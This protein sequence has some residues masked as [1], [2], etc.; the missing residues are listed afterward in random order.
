MKF[1]NS[2]N[3]TGF[4]FGLAGA[5]L[6]FASAYLIIAQSVTMTQNGMGMTLT[7][8]TNPSGI[9]WGVGLAALG[10]VLIVTA[11]VS[12]SSLSRKRMVT[13]GRLMFAYGIVMLL[14]GTSMLSGLTPMMAGSVP[15][16]LGMF[17][18]GVL[19]IFNGIAMGRSHKM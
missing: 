16:S 10:I 2:S 5:L 3:V 1:S 14:V 9:I 15:S 18:I 19:M 8:Y 11:F 12:L 6:D 4:I 17:A 7:E 13:I